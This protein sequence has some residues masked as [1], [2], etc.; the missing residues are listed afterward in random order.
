MFFYNKMNVNPRF[1]GPAIWQALFAC[2]YACP[3]SRFE[4]LSTLIM[5]YVPLILPCE[6][7]RSHFLEKNEKVNKRT[8]G[9][10]AQ[11]PST[12]DEMFVWLYFLKDEVNLSLK[13]RSTVSLAE[14][15]NRLEGHG[16]LV[17]ETVLANSIVLMAL[18]VSSR[19]DA[20]ARLQSLED[21]M[22]AFC[23]ALYTLLPI[24]STSALMVGLKNFQ[25]PIVTNAVRMAR[26]TLKSHGLPTLSIAHY[27]DFAEM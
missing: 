27:R 21:V 18:N 24:P 12:P 20:D 13:T 15:R 26:L 4:S 23:H 7:C 17:H 9:R 14:L 1:W 3:D 16:P 25:R 6:G 8:F 10:K 5:K 2:S 11:S 22:I 19:I